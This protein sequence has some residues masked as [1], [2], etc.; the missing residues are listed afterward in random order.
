MR[1]LKSSNEVDFKLLDEYE[2][3]GNKDLLEEWYHS[4]EAVIQT[5]RLANQT[6]ATPYYKS[7]IDFYGGSTIYAS[8]IEVIN[9]DILTYAYEAV[10]IL[11]RTWNPEKSKFSTYVYNYGPSRLMRVRDEDLGQEVV[12]YTEDIEDKINGPYLLN[13]ERRVA[14]E[15][16]SDVVEDLRDTWSYR[17]ECVLKYMVGE[18]SK[19]ETLLNMNIKDSSLWYYQ[20]QTI[21]MMK[22]S[23]PIRAVNNYGD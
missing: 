14:E 11:L 1:N 3:T 18:T 12:D 20:S 15:L 22:D 8:D 5:M 16:L 21:D 6:S 23:E 4:E 19:E 10:G 17:N 13:L 9:P 2:K 7:V